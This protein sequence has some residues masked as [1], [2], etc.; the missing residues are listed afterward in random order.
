MERVE[1]LNCGPR[2]TLALRLATQAKRIEK[3][4]ESLDAAIEREHEAEKDCDELAI[5]VENLEDVGSGGL[6]AHTGVHIEGGDSKYVFFRIDRIRCSCSMDV[7]YG[8]FLVL[9]FD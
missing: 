7:R 3:L 1:R 8:N 6:G 5:R 2:T 9:A 4:Q